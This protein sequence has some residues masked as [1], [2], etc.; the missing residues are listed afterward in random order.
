[1]NALLAI[2]GIVV[3]GGLVYYFLLKSGKVKDEN[4]N[5]VPDSVE[6][7]ATKVKKQATLVKEEV[8]EVAQKAKELVQ[9]AEVKPKA[10]RT[11]RKPAAKKTAEPKVEKTVVVESKNP[12]RRKS[13][14]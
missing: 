4:G 11:T 14:K 7:A 12:R 5:M 3:V 10:K 2:L 13:N 1:M 6:E 9:T 8:K